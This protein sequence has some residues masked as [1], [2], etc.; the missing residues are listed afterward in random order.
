M[1]SKLTIEIDFSDNNTPYIQILEDPSQDVRDQ[2]I[3]S[4]IQSLAH[5]STWCKIVPH[6]MQDG[7]PK[8]WIIKAITPAQIEQ[9]TVIMIEQN[10]LYKKYREGCSSS[11]D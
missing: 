2:L 10:R 5:Q 6:Y 8:K 4:F 11:M 1:K 7:Y 3:C 9:E